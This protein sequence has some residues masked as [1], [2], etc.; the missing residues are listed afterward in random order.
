MPQPLIPINFNIRIKDFE[1][2]SLFFDIFSNQSHE[3]FLG[4]ENLVRSSLYL[5]ENNF[6][7]FSTPRPLHSYDSGE[8]MSL[9][10]QNKITLIIYM[11][12][13]IIYRSNNTLNL[14][15]REAGFMIK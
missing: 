11:D 6:V 15:E 13:E 5:Q 12:V 2:K 4:V 10:T 9:Q 14:C 3:R 8:P 7:K 1:F